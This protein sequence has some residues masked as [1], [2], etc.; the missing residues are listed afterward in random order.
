MA[1]ILKNIKRKALELDRKHPG[2]SDIR[3]HCDSV[4]ESMWAYG[5][6]ARRCT[7]DE[8]RKKCRLLVLTSST[9]QMASFA[10]PI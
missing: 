9:N 6:D 10:S 4:G 3:I 8:I 2:L 1:S 7:E 5:V